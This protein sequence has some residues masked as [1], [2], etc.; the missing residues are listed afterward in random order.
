M[1]ISQE[2]FLRFLK[3][4]CSPEEEALVSGFFK[5][6]P[7]AITQYLQQEEW[8][9]IDNNGELSPAVSEQMLAHINARLFK[10]AVKKAR[11]KQL[12]V[13]MRW[14]AAA[15][16]VLM[17]VLWIF[18]TI[19]PSNE[20]AAAIIPAAG[21]D[22]ALTPALAETWEEHYNAKSKPQKILLK[23]GSVILLYRHSVVRYK[24][25]FN[26]DKRDVYLDGTAFFEVAKDKKR[27]FTVFGGNL[28]TTALGTSFMVS[29]LKDAGA[30]LS[31]KLFT[32]KVIVRSLKYL[33]GWYK[34]TVLIPG[35]QL[36]Y[37]PAKQA[38]TVM[39]FQH[40]NS[41]EDNKL[42]AAKP[43]EELRFSNEALYKVFD[44]IMAF[45]KI[46]IQYNR[47]DIRGMNFT[48]SI[49]LSDDAGVILNLIAQMNQLKVIA[50][51]GTGT[52]TINRAGKQ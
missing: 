16:I 42:K 45:R 35:Q 48:G 29:A 30:D 44:D 41:N 15:C 14:A 13:Y 5:N 4:E 32:G 23:D 50:V 24:A 40:Q 11:R 22:T 31:V 8:D 36:V 49:S 7:G 12:Q 28:S 46:N 37:S 39:A 26:G 33:P 9:A 6:D 2:Q 10:V 43:G 3:N 25:S 38:M 19:S 20:N 27:P 51:P 21:K 47:E 17:P 1:Q 34:D 18:K 52:F